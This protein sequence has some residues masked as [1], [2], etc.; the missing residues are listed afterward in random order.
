M[1]LSLIK[2]EIHIVDRKE[3]HDRVLKAT[4]KAQ[5]TSAYGE[6]AP[7]YDADVVDDGGYSGFKTVCD[8]LMTQ[9][10]P[11]TAKI[12]DAG[13]GTGLAGQVL[14]EEGYT[15]VHGLDFSHDMLE[16]AA[17]KGVYQRYIQADLTASLDL[18][19]DEFDAIVCAGTFTSGHVGPEAL[20]EMIRVTRPGGLICFTVR[21][22][23]WENDNFADYIR[24]LS[25]GD[26]WKV[27]TSFETEYLKRD[28]SLCQVCVCQ[29]A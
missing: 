4:D 8:E 14:A 6:W 19:D 2:W 26:A 5:L 29:V 21:D 20:D 11:V 3:I 24:K 9:R 25:D 27:V 10:V 15:D 16:E 22:E 13:C 23:A 18:D 1:G 17:R 12:L 28:E 7:D